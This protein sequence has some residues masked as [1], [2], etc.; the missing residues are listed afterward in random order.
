[1]TLSAL[2]P[3]ARRAREL[4]EY[5]AD[6]GEAVD[7][8][9]AELPRVNDAALRPR[10]VAFVQATDAM[11]AMHGGAAGPEVADRLNELLNG[12]HELAIPARDPDLGPTPTLER[13]EQLTG[14]VAL[15]LIKSLDAAATMGWLPGKPELPERLTAAVSRAEV[16]TLLD[17]IADRLDAVGTS[18]DALVAASD[19]TQ[20]SAWQ[21]GLVNFYVGSIRVEISLAKMQLAVGE[22][23]VD[24]A[25]LWRTAETIGELTGDF[26]ET[27][28]GWAQ[29]A[30]LAVMQASELV[31]RR[32]RKVVSGVGAAVRF[33]ARKRR[34][35]EFG[36]P[37]DTGQIDSAPTAHEHEE[38]ITPFAAPGD[39]DLRAA[40]QMIA[41]GR[42]PPEAWRPFIIS[43]NSMGPQISS[44]SPLVG[45]INLQSLDL[46]FE[47]VGDL[48]PLA[49]LA[50]LRRLYL[51]TAQVKDL[52][53]LTG[54]TRV[55]QLELGP[56]EVTDLSPLAALTG[57]QELI[58]ARTPV[59]DLSPLAGLSN[60]Q[61]LSVEGTQVRDLSP[62]AGLTN[63]QTL[64]VQGTKVSDLSPLA[65]L[66]NLETL[67]VENTQV[68]DLSP[69]VALTKLRELYLRRTLVSDLSPLA[70][71]TN[72]QTLDVERTQVSDLSPLAGLSSLQ[73]LELRGTRASDVSPLAVLARLQRLVLWDTQVSDLSALAGLTDLQYLD[74][75]NTQVSDVSTLAGLT[76]LTALGLNGTQVSDVSPLAGL[77][78]LTRIELK[79]T[80]VTDVSSLAGNKELRIMG[81]ATVQSRE[82]S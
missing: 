29:R 40:E 11:L 8:L 48:S 56:S 47:S 43:L 77:T 31:H 76:H 12:V 13:I 82:L 57:L 71:L 44:P 74:L 33:V 80:Q 62:L 59:S 61:L 20:G 42:A 65:G 32:V 37:T 58:L 66:T 45:L 17:R 19:G 75:D 49:G 22:S 60:L 52:S 10:V 73:R 14:V 2:P 38:T 35:A 67:H 28:R 50:S 30:S 4:A 27:L 9:R 46:R 25:A 69:L 15:R 41:A 68:R 70:R 51:G 7:K 81:L 18:L 72:L 21:T 78:R 55:Q 1:M 26:Y 54:L 36:A 79:D 16:G 53:T 34:N 3:G 39:F 6:L 63:L 64:N 24:F 5:M 23:T